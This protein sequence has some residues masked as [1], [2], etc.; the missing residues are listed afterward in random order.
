MSAT[1]LLSIFFHDGRYHGERRRGAGEWPPA[2]ARI[3]QALVAGAF[4]GAT[5]A[6]DDRTLAEEAEKFANALEWLESLDAPAIAAAAAR[7]GQS[8]SNFVP[9]ND[10]DVVD[11]GSKSANKIRTD[12]TIRTHIF[13]PGIPL[14]FIWKFN[15][16]TAENGHARTVC[17][18]AERIYQVGRGVDMAWARGEL[19][20]GSESETR[21]LAEHGGVVHRPRKSGEG[22][23]LLCPRKGS[24]A[25]LRNRFESR[26]F[27]RDPQGRMVR[28]RAPDARFV[29]VIYNCSPERHLF[30]MRRSA[31]DGSF[32]PWPFTRVVELVIDLRDKAVRRLEEGLPQN[33]EAKVGRVLVG[34]GAT[35]ADK[36][37]RTRIL[38]LPSI[39]H[40]H[41]DHEIRRVLVEIPP[42]C[43]LRADDIVWAFSGLEETHPATGEVSWS[44]VRS[45]EKGMLDR[46][47]VR[48]PDGKGF[49]VW[50]TVTPAALPVVR[51][52]RHGTGLG[53]SAA[54]AESAEAVRQ[55]LRHAG[56][57]TR[58]ASILVQREPFDRNGA[59]AG[60]FA[61]PDRFPARG[62]R[63]VEVAFVQ[64]VCGSLV[65]GNGRYMG[66]GLMAPVSDYDDVFVFDLETTRRMAH[67]DRDVLLRS[68]RRALMARARDEA[69]RVD[70]LFSG[71]E[72]GGGADR[73]GN[74][75]S[76]FLAVDGGADGDES[77]RL[78]VAAPWAADRRAIPRRGDRALFDEVIRKLDELRGRLDR[79][80]GLVPEAIEDGDPLIGPARTWV[81][82]TPY[83]ATRNLKRKDDPAAMVKGDVVAECRR[84]GLPA[85]ASVDVLHVV[86]GPRGGRPTAK[87]RLSFAVAVRGPLLLGRD[88]HAGGGLFRATAHQE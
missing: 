74:H 65:I 29:P 2:P 17:E 36:S 71:H 50:R 46:Y 52:D 55:A 79:F 37:A 48:D 4:N 59:R 83:A 23:T 75:A 81:G 35:D 24:L 6:G 20:D 61:T 1:L 72:S 51:T 82:A 67:D 45:D 86:A 28:Q 42:A 49:R 13:D 54:E 47:G 11:G 41:A 9:N 15:D 56:V 53:R 14:L 64:A 85:P 34:R 5:M 78:V 44:L 76:V 88:S 19:L 10:R 27:G 25:S 3:F 39:G 12:K 32:A 22:V 8:F 77:A 66:L 16:G 30:E 84:R 68:L 62:L 33:E 43:P 80:R 63:H 60:D 26:R 18:I 7:K 58:V 57:T 69:G 38:P 21:V 87:L 40:T 70:R 73:A 31:G